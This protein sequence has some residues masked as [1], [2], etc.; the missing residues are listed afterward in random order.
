MDHHNIGSY[1]AMPSR[2]EGF[3]SKSN[4]CHKDYFT[5]LKCSNA[6]MLTKRILST[7]HLGFLI[8][9]KILIKRGWGELTKA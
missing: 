8:N 5:K 6:Q 7:H 2:L 3:T 9:H 4:K 1:K